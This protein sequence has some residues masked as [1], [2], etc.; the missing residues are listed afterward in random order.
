MNKTMLA[1]LDILDKH[2][3]EIIGSR[4]ISRQLRLHGVELTERTV[5]YHL[6][7]MDEKGF[8]RVFGKEG[9]KITQKGREELASAM[10]SARVGFIISKIETLSFQ[11]NFDMAR[12]EGDIIINVSFLAEED[13]REAL[14]VMRPVFSSP[15]VMSD[16]V[17][18]ARAGEKVGDLVVPEGKV[19]LGTVCS[20][21]VNGIFLK[22]GIPVTSRFGGL[23]QVDEEG[24]SRFVALISYEGSSLDP[25]V[26][27]I[28]SRMT[29]VID[30]VRHRAGKVLASFREIPVV[31]VEKAVELQERLKAIGIGGIL[32]IGNPNQPIYEMPVSVDKAGMVIV[33][34][35]N[36]IAALEESGI[37]TD[38][39]AMAALYG[40]TDLIPFKEALRRHGR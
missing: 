12:Q 34:G 11:T 36:P 38:S 22:A 5:R 30:A 33:G 32:L 35:L 7:I 6:K 10:V 24:P 21:T 3:G 31:S 1:I 14:G 13:L 20:V 40:Y 16:R 26:V 2:Q 19:A 29:S 27:F 15:Y 23:L 25:L 8:T 18:L 39:A 28:K 37:P 17:I 4:E 9:R